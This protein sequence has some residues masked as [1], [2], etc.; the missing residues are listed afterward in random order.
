MDGQLLSLDARRLGRVSDILGEWASDGSFELTEIAVGPEAVA[1]RVSGRV[2]RLLER[3]LHGRFEHT[4]PLGDVE[5]LGA[6]VRLSR[7]AD[8]YELG[9]ADEWIVRRILRFIP[10]SGR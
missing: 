1:R 4:I 10:G 5:E 6:T 9:S 2:A 3:V 7:P 8:E